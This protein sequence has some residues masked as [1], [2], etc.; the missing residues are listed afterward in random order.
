MPVVREAKSYPIGPAQTRLKN[1][2]ENH[3]LVETRGRGSGRHV[4]AHRR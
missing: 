1:R 3:I 4:G 2:E